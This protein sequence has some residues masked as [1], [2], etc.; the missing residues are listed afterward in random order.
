MDYHRERGGMSL[1]D[2]VQVHCRKGSTTGIKGLVPS[3]W[4][5]VCMLVNYACV[6]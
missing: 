4:A 5:K 3:I 2:E 1:H 6:I